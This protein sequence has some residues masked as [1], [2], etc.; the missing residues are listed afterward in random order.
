[1]NTTERCILIVDDHAL[2]RAGLAM[3]LT[4]DALTGRIVEA[5]TVREAQTSDALLLHKPVAA[6]HLQR[7]LAE[8]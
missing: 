2:F 3:I 4:Q 7:A 5:G 8:L 6:S 1:M